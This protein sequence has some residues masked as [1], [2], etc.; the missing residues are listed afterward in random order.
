MGSLGEIGRSIASALGVR[1]TRADDDEF[2]ARHGGG[3]DALT[4]REA[5]A[6]DHLAALRS[7]LDRGG[8]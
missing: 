7:G 8:P 1:A 4:E 3:L 2:T 5:A 6:A